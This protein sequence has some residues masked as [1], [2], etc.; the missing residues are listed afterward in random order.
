VS[1]N[2]VRKIL[3]EN[4]LDP[5]PARGRGTWDDFL[6]IH[7]ATLWQ[8]DF[9]S[10]KV[11][12][13]KGLRDIFVLVFLHVETRRV[14]V[15]PATF[16]TGDAWMREQAEAFLHHG[17]QSGLKAD[18]VMAAFS[19]LRFDRAVASLAYCR[20]RGSGRP[21]RAP[22]VGDRGQQGC[23]LVP[24]TTA[25]RELGTDLIIAQGG[26]WAIRSPCRPSTIF[27][28]GIRT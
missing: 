23:F 11:L 25:R 6:K 9:F 27:K 5:G 22:V 1:Q 15:T 16:K 26:G 8:C 13:P 2:T 19:K 24:P 17:K 20:S 4:G 3:K 28:S 14:F 10:K 21:Y 7:V 18:I 12:T